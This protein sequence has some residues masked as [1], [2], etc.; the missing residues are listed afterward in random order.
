MISRVIPMYPESEKVSEIFK[1]I[2]FQED[3]NTAIQL[4][5]E[6]DDGSDR[7]FAE[8]W[9]AAYRFL[10]SRVDKALEDLI[11]LE[12]VNLKI[13][14][15]MIEFLVKV[16]YYGSYTNTNSPNFGSDQAESALEEM[17][18]SY[19]HLKELDLSTSESDFIDCFYNRKLT[20]L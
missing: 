1:V 18:K 6:L 11:K 12:N 8:F 17:E 7:L 15:P 9:L 19:N 4:I 10:S 5:G 16:Q 13:Q 14:N 20:I 2:W 3:T